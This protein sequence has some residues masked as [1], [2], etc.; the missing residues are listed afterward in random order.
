LPFFETLVQDL[1]Y[2]VRTLCR[3]PGYANV[4]ILTLAVGI[5]VNTAIF[6]FFYGLIL[7]PLPVKDPKSVVFAYNA[8]PRQ[9]YGPVSYP[10]FV[11]LRD[12][13]TVLSGFSVFGG[14]RMTLTNEKD[15]E[16]NSTGELLQAMMVSSDYFSLLGEN[17]AIGRTFL[18]EED[19]APGAHP[20]AVL[21]YELWQTRFGGDPGIIGKSLT[22][23]LLPYTVIGIA[24][25]NFD[26][27]SPQHIDLWVPVAMQ[28]NVAPGVDELSERNAYWL[29]TV[30]RLKPGVTRD[31]AQAALSVLERQYSAQDKTDKSDPG[32]IALTAVTLVDPEGMEIAMP[33]AGVV[34]LAIGLVLL[35]VCANVAN[36]ALARGVGRQKEIGIR[37][38]LGA[39]RLRVVRQLLTESLLLGLCGGA[40]GLLLAY[41]IA[42]GILPFFH[43]PGEH[44]LNLNVRPD[45]T[46]LVY[47]MA[48][49]LLCGVAFGLIPALRFS[50]QDLVGTMKEVGTSGGRGA[51]SSRL[52]NMLVVTQ[53]A[54]SLFLLIGAGL[55]V[56]ALW[57]AQKVDPGF[58]IHNVLVLKTD[59]RLHE[60]NAARAT[61]FENQMEERLKAMPGVAG[62]SLGA[63][64][65]LGDSF[66]TT[67]LD[68]D[69]R[70][71]SAGAPIH[72][73]NFNRVR[74][75]YFE[76]LGVPIVQGREFTQ[77][78]AA[79]ERKVAVVS[80]STAWHF[81]PG[82]NP[83]G[84]KFNSGVEVIGV[85]KDVRSVHL[86]AANEL[87]LYELA[88]SQDSTSLM[89]FVRTL[90]NP[91]GI[92]RS[93]PE[94]AHSID[95]QISLTGSRLEDNLAQW[96]WPAEMGA[97]LSG[98]LGL[99]ALML[100]L[101]GIYGVISYAVN[102]RTHEIGVRMALGAQNSHVLRLVI[103]QGM[104]LVL[105]GVTIGILISLAGSRLL[106]Q[107][108]YGL[109]AVD[110]GTFAG[111]AVL[112]AGVAMLACWIPVRRAMRVDPM[113]ALRYE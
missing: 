19:G 85:A 36:L 27:L 58:A 82:Q 2:A 89:I 76:T 13:N 93:L 107:Y 59:M 54:M 103:G 57:K 20:V 53:V 69:D 7:R 46:V 9:R 73:V 25:R 84:K 98:A 65:P 3:A 48:L 6:S 71:F 62:V 79:E 96:I 32:R 38:A 113:V 28:S 102:Q 72:F 80:Q 8:A 70:S 94:V 88:T 30:G 34:M 95:P 18:P 75:E 92:I 67:N 37:L 68:P 66:W 104:R 106:A 49:S 86:Y 42:D 35:I 14:A 111:V 55:M 1:K 33:I 23:N 45:L 81:W 100:A 15:P 12:H 47:T 74:P 110:A 51:S 108:L 78:D 4:V 29:R 22:L 109:S 63:L 97:L 31:Q 50:K 39:G 11:Y 83:I 41:W 87:V 21:S 10:E 43:P 77:A 105:L 56:R 44:A 90:G 17:A 112:L 16:A 52:R 5:G 91:M 26:G 24:P 99:L 40:A 64:A 61:T 60:Y 101:T